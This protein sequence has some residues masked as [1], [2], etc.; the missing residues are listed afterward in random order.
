MNEKKAT[1]ILL[2][3]LKGS[4]RKQTNLLE[5]ADACRFLL[6][7]EEWGS[8]KMSEFFKISTYMLRQIDRI[9]DLFVEGNNLIKKNQIGI[10]QAYQLSRI[11]DDKIQN[12]TAKELIKLSAHESRALVNLLL[13]SKTK[14]VKKITREY[15]KE[16]RAQ[17]HLVVLPLSKKAF[18]EL[19]KISKDKKL[20][21]HEIIQNILEDA[22]HA[23]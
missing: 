8:Q 21:I 7:H 14:N 17:P 12:Q 4:K 1:A 6:Q 18:T 3:N 22:I 10:E 11:K 9:N 20:T 23:R 13:E 15:K 16:D 5:V 19:T 2:A